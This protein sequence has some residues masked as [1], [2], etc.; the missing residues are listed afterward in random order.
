MWTMVF[1]SAIHLEILKLYLACIQ[2]KHWGVFFSYQLVCMESFYDQ[3][4]ILSV[5]KLSLKVNIAYVHIN[6]GRIWLQV[7]WKQKEKPCTYAKLLRITYI[8]SKT[9]SVSKFITMFL[10]SLSPKSQQWSRNFTIASLPSPGFS[11][12]QV[13]QHIL[14]PWRRE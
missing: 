2:I 6:V 5:S 10:L 13:W 7:D 1:H 9:V 3:V 12:T 8:E 11:L 4:Y 14:L